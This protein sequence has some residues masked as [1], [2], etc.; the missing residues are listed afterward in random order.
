MS[1]SLQSTAASN[2]QPGKAHPLVNGTNAQEWPAN[3]D[4]SIP[5]GLLFHA[6]GEARATLLC[7][8][9]VQTH[10][11][12]FAPLARELTRG[13]FNVIAVDR[14]GSGVNAA[15]PFVRGHTKGS[16][17]LLDDLQKQMRVAKMMGPPVYLLGTSW[18]SNLAAVYVLRDLAPQADGLILLVPATRS[19][20]EHWFSKPLAGLISFLFPKLTAKLPFQ[21]VHYQAGEQQPPPQD[22]DQPPLKKPKDGTPW[23]A[24][25]DLADQLKEDEKSGLLLT[26]PTY[27]LLYT[28]LA[29]A[30]EWKSSSK[31]LTIPGLVILAGRDQI[32]DNAAAWRAVSQH[33]S[34]AKLVSLEDA[35]HGAQITSPAE[36]ADS[37]SK[38]T[39]ET[40]DR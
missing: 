3:A 31:Q 39:R 2:R 5:K 17:E 30:S 38:W 40:E 22:L 10:A 24:S 36:I 19:R 7:L 1:S 27:R 6:Q 8:H 18:G 32:M 14:R 13:G 16:Q 25:A 35:G 12:W 37:I 9:G 23:R 29:L 4:P 20:F 21:A 33:S 34:K 15:A 26:R 28:G 11:A